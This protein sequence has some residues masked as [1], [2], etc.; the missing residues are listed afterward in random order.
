MPTYE[1]IKIDTSVVVEE[2]R[3]PLFYIDEKE[4]TILDPVPADVVAAYLDDLDEYGEGRALSR[5]LHR[6]LGEDAL[7]DLAKAGPA[8]TEQ[9]MKHV[10]GIAS[11]LLM[12]ALEKT[13]GKSNR[14]QRRSRG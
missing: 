8:F 6:L 2:R 10:M 3:V 7:A 12:G 1:P 5:A 13:Q 14:A 11:E 4:Y 9:D